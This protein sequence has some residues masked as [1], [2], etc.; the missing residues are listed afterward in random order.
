[1]TEFKLPGSTP[2]PDTGITM[3]IPPAEFWVVTPAQ[4]PLAENYHLWLEEIKSLD[5]K[6]SSLGPRVE[7]SPDDVFSL[8]V[9]G[10][11]PLDIDKLNLPMAFRRVY[12]G[13]LPLKSILEAV[14]RPG[15]ISADIVM[16]REW[17]TFWE[18]YH[19]CVVKSLTERVQARRVA[20]TQKRVKQGG[21]LREDGTIFL[22][23]MPFRS[24]HLLDASGASVQPLQRTL[25]HVEF[26]SGGSIAW[27]WRATYTNEDMEVMKEK[28]DDW[29][30]VRKTLPK[31]MKDRH[32]WI[33]GVDGVGLCTIANMRG[34]KNRIATGIKTVDVIVSNS[35]H[36]DT[37][38]AIAFSLL[39]LNVGGYAII[40]LGR[41]ISPA[42]ISLIHLFSLSFGSVSIFHTVASDRLFLCGSDY[43]APLGARYTRLL[44][45]FCEKIS[46]AKGDQH[47]GISLWSDDYMRGRDF[48]NTV[49]I[50]LNV[51]R[52]ICTWRL[53]RYTK[54]IRVAEKI[55]SSG[56]SKTFPN[57]IPKT[58]LDEFPDLSE[59]W[60]GA[61]EFSFF[62][63]VKAEKK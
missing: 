43:Q 46:P 55:V 42:L 12:E 15:A 9:S 59:Q 25:N 62:L 5:E 4:F 16:G 3:G 27:D 54:M 61:T 1:M 14:R 37:E 8:D 30:D 51:N 58:I 63:D 22:R 44:M 13:Q 41:I 23:G 35:S 32:H 40:R 7:L 6:Y 33:T 18:I 57:F 19:R 11:P 28:A 17:L 36:D 20:A 45:E 47:R 39:N 34:W 38:C 21:K 26:L 24:F 31:F 49:E 2:D 52:A 10:N 50:L 56:S 53:Q 48:T 60:I 29:A